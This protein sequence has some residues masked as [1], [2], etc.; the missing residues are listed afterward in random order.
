ML[1]SEN[2]HHDGSKS[3]DHQWR[4]SG[5]A[6][7]GFKGMSQD[8]LTRAQIASTHHAPSMAMPASTQQHMLL[9]RHSADANRW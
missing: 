7:A 8:K 1:K 6:I 4:S 2:K 3:E 9:M 5:S